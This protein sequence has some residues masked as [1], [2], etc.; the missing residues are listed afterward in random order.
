MVYI[1]RIFVAG[2]FQILMQEVLKCQFFPVFALMYLPPWK[3][4]LGMPWLYV[5]KYQWKSSSRRKC[6]IH[7]NPGM[8]NVEAQKKNVLYDFSAIGIKRMRKITQVKG[9]DEYVYACINT[10]NIFILIIRFVI[11]CAAEWLGLDIFICT[12]RCSCVQ[13]V[14]VS[15]TPLAWF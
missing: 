13:H 8:Q 4:C 1:P 9:S 15:G 12:E 7:P 11:I 6:P 10:Y 14:Q 2:P 5:S 3:I